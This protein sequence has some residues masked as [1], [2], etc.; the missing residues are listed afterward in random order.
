[1]TALVLLPGLDGTGRLFGDFV[2]ALGIEANAVIVSYPPDEAL[3]YDQLEALVRTR[4]PTDE[5]FVLLG[6]SFSGPIALSIA[7][8]AP[9]G[10]R[11]LVLCCTFVKNPRPMLRFLKAIIGFISV[12]LM[13][14]KLLGFVLL[15]RFSTSAA[16]RTLAEVR[17]QV[18]SKALRARL[19][20]V[21]DLDVTCLLPQV[22]VPVLYLCATED[23]VVPR[24]AYRETSRLLL[25]AKVIEIRGPHFLLQSA[26]AEAA[27]HVMQFLRDVTRL[28][29]NSYE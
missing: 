4:L 19:A 25:K 2:D 28:G 26:P 24:A 1:M 27:R 5:A 7:A 16:R 13:P 29:E 20:A 21:L 6:E 10:L 18:S 8:S 17:A 3:D 14:V 9:S 15:G 12:G 22:R 11:G 23:R